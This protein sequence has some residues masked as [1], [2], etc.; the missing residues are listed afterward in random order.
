MVLYIYA[1][2]SVVV[3]LVLASHKLLKLK[4]SLE[5]TLKKVEEIRLLEM[6]LCNV[7]AGVV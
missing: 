6:K 5:N 3:I 4:K 1:N 2:A 7:F